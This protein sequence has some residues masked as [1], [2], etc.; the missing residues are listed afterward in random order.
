MSGLPD[1]L[2]QGL[3]ITERNTSTA[4]YTGW[5]TQYFYPRTN[6]TNF[7]IRKSNSS[8]DGWTTWKKFVGI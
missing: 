5:V 3:L 4:G 2:T 8:D 6:S 7:Y 1:S